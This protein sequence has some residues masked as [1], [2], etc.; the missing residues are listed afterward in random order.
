MSKPPTD[1]ATWLKLSAH[2]D[3]A[4][5]LTPVER[6]AWLENLRATEPQIADELKVMLADHRQLR[7][8]GFLDGAA[9]GERDMSLA[10]VIVGSYTLMSRIGTGGMGTVWLGRRSDGRYEGS[11][12]VKLLNAALVGRSGEERFRREGVILARLSHPHIAHLIDAGVSNTGQPYLV[13]ELVDG[14]HIDTYCDEQR[15][16]IP[17]RVQLFLDVLS[18]VAHAHSSLIVHRDLK[19]SNVLVTQTG[20]VKLLDF[21]IA[22][23]MEEDGVSRLT[24]DAGAVLTPKY[25]A[26][27]QVT[28]GP[29]TT[30]TDV[31]ALGV[32]L[33]EL[34]SGQHPYGAA[35]QSSSDFTRAIVEQD[36]LPLSAAFAKA[37][38]EA[39]SLAAAQRSTTPDRMASVLG[40]E[41]ETILNKALKKAPSER[42]SAVAELTD[43]LRRYLDDKPIAA[44]PDTVRYRAAKFVR[45]HRRGLAVAAAAVAG[46]VGMTAV[47]AWRVTTE[48]DRAQ[49]QAEK[50]SRVSELLRSVLITADPYRDPDRS[51][52]A[53]GAP[54]A[55]VILD[56]LAAR[57]STE[58]N[59]QPE[60]QVEMLTVIGRTY[61]RLGLLDRALP[62]LE[63]ALEI[64]RQSFQLPDAR[65]AQTLDDLGV[66]HRRMGNP[67]ASPAPLLEALTMRRALTGND[68][69]DVAVTLS[70]YGRTLRELGRMAESDGPTREALAIRTKLFG[71]EHRE[72]ATNKSD[73]GLLMLDLG[74]VEEA[75]RLFR[76]N[77]AT[78]EALLGVEHPNSAAAKNYVGTVLAIRGDYAAAQ[79]LQREALDVRRRVFGAANPESAFAV[80]SLAFT[81]EVQGRLQEAEAM[82]TEAY[83][84][85]LAASTADNPRV[86]AMSVDLARVRVAAGKAASVESMLTLALS[87]RQRI[88]PEGHWRIAE[89]QSLLGASLAAQGRAEE[90]APLMLA[91]DRGLSAIQGRA[92]DREAN[93]ARL[94]RLPRLSPAGVSR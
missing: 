48:R 19:P 55:R 34:V 32:L 46:I 31:Y 92:R 71:N 60:V 18:A 61:E 79:R 21:S 27:E 74:K 33:Y 84:R 63:R 56:T 10:G 29:V 6:D 93:R 45:R 3:H 7:E 87:V 69:K 73:L 12:A 8:E 16:S 26:P 49:V 9:I 30:G 40:K 54:N 38:P 1:T 76:E 23:L 35:V 13:L 57:I 43:D 20:T 70:E 75:E 89:V 68:D 22:K 82:L 25:A 15:L 72:T 14:E 36:P 81:L 4:L 44:R 2:L 86:V 11:V 64:G 77:L 24:Q 91:A 80:Q 39:R 53:A 28:G 37:S 83:E 90:A 42:Y 66:L 85:V 51:V 62:L 65:V 50:A 94:A 88:Y 41:L 5:E 58:L 47:Y 67:S 17:K 59:D 78:T 52:E